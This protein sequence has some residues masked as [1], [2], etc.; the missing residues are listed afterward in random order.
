MNTPRDAAKVSV[1]KAGEIADEPDDLFQ[2][3]V[4]NTDDKI[5]GYVEKWHGSEWIY[6]DKAATRWLQDKRCSEYAPDLNSKWRDNG[7]TGEEP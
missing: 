5:I 1:A 4:E 3:S 6:A 2:L 7:R